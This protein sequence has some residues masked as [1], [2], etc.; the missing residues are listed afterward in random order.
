MKSAEKS[1]PTRMSNS[2]CIEVLMSQNLVW[3]IIRNLGSTTGL[4]TPVLQ[5]KNKLHNSSPNVVDKTR[6]TY[7]KS[8]LV[9]LSHLTLT[10][11]L[12]QTRKVNKY[13][14]D[15]VNSLMKKRC[16]YSHISL[17]LLLIFGGMK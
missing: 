5:K 1:M 11:L 2:L 16:L 15:G 3:I 8:T 4:L 12:I 17:L 14:K 10:L 6:N 13:I 9:V 7:M